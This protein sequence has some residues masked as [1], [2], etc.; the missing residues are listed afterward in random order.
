MDNSSIKDNIRKVRMARNIT[1]E[2]MADR[3]DISL[4][5]YKAL[6]KGKTKIVNANVI[7]MAQLL[8]TSTEELVLGYH[9]VQAPGQLLEDVRTEYGGRI[10]ALERRIEDLERLVK[11]LE[12]T[13][14]TK[15][16]VISML[17]KSASE[18][19]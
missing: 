19:N 18:N 4:T 2:S 10:K 16:E 6:E 5:A 12:D 11:T 9:P 17:K 14:S 3:L 8:E 7:K 15:N 1:Q 13:I